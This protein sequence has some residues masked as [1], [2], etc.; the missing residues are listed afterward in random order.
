MTQE[1]TF[2]SRVETPDAHRRSN[3]C[4]ENRQV[5]AKPVRS[6]PLLASAGRTVGSFSPPSIEPDRRPLTLPADHPSNNVDWS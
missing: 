6:G 3:D 4:G 1:R 5:G 2:T